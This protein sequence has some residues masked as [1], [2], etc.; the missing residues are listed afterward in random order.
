MI[1]RRS[2]MPVFFAALLAA[3]GPMGETASPTFIDGDPARML[4][5]PADRYLVAASSTRPETDEDAAG[6]RIDVGPYART[7]PA[8]RG[9]PEVAEGLAGLDGFGTSAELAI[10]LTFAPEITALAD[11]AT[12]F[13]RSVGEDSPIHLI[14]IDP[15]DPEAG[16]PLAFV[17]RFE[18]DGNVLFLRPS[19]PFRPNGWYAVMV[20]PGLRD[21]RGRRFEAPTGFA[22]LWKGRRGTELER[23]GFHRLR[24]IVID[25]PIYAFTFRTGSITVKLR[26]L[27]DAVRGSTPSG[28]TWTTRA[29]WSG[30]DAVDV[31]VE[32]WFTHEDYRDGIG[33]LTRRGQRRELLRFTLSLPKVTEAHGEPFPVVLAQHGFGGTRQGMLHLADAFARRGLALVTIDAPN[34][35]S[36]GPGEGISG[37]FLVGLRETFGIHTDGDSLRIRGWYFRDLLRQQVLTHL[38]LLR[39]LEAWQGDVPRDTNQAGTDLT[40]EQPGLIGHSMGAVMS[41]VGG[42]AV[43]EF[44][45][46]VLNAG[47]G[48]ITDVFARN[49]R[50]DELAILALRPRGTSRADGW[51]MVQFLQATI[52]PGDPINYVRHRVLEPFAGA[53]PRPVLMQNALDDTLVANHASFALARAA[54]AR[55]IGPL[56]V[57]TPGLPHAAGP[58]GRYSGEDLALIAFRKEVRVGD[59]WV[60]ADHGNILWSDSSREQAATF[61]AEGIVVSP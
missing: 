31:L 11:P 6:Y 4:P 56:F 40:L 35:G 57:A 45:R 47:G 9:V 12:A 21:I 15:E 44:G 50:V 25:R 32:G 26:A 18:Y 59:A 34:H 20:R 54:G 24:E 1:H 10:G 60:R 29:P 55:L 58:R 17:A 52:D 8:L 46:V 14:S 23:E 41:G 51:R 49:A 30:H 36:R 53:T 16:R 22:D 48:R 7:D 61:L 3:C 33:R 28:V 39:A 13:D 5:F 19:L 37:D 27:L 43:R 2:T 42:A 38:Q